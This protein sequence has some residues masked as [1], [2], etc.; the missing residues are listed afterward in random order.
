MEHHYYVLKELFVLYSNIKKLREKYGLT[1]NEMADIL[2]IEKESLISLEAYE[3][4]D[5]LYDFH[6]KNLCNYFSISPDNL[7]KENWL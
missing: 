1:V 7:F 6:I 2:D 4:I 3:N 5:I